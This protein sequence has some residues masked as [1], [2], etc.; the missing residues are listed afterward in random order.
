MAFRFFDVMY[1]FCMFLDVNP[2]F[3]EVVGI[4][5]LRVRI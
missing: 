2:G 4:L 5:S 1:F 3:F